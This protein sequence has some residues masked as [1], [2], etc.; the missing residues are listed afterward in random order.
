MNKNDYLNI[1]F[2]ELLA[3]WK[4][5]FQIYKNPEAK[6]SDILNAASNGYSLGG[7]LPVEQGFKLCV[8][9]RVI[10]IETDSR[11]KLNFAGKKTIENHAFDEPNQESLRFIVNQIIRE[12]RLPWVVFSMSEEVDFRYSLPDN[13]EVILDNCG[14]LDFKKE[15]VVKWWKSLFHKYNA[16]R[17]ERIKK[18]GD[19]GEFLTYKLEQKRISNDGFNANQFVKWVASFDDSQGFD[20]ISLAGRLHTGQDNDQIKIEVK[21]SERSFKEKFQ[22]F[23]TRNEWNIAIEQPERYLFYCWIGIK[24]NGEYEEGPFTF[25]AEDI[26]SHIPED[27]SEFGVWN[28][29]KITLDLNKYDL[30]N[31]HA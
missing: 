22:F 12:N 31:S 10:D 20:I 30:L 11:V 7:S 13:W 17:E 23:L 14:L 15:M 19:I 9:Q 18:I 8:H 24:L 29:C 4:I 6:I 27:Q 2:V 1:K 26:K 21:S 16:E 28:Q 5:L 3:Y 25:S